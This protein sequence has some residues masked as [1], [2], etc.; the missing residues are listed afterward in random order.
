LIVIEGGDVAELKCRRTTFSM[1]ASDHD[2]DAALADFAERQLVVGDRGPISVGRSNATLSP[3]LPA[4]QERLVARRWCPSGVPKPAKL[5]ASSRAC[6]GSR[7]GECRGCREKAPGSLTSRRKVDA[8]DI[9]GRC[10]GDRSAGRKMVVKLVAR[11][12]DFSS[13][14]APNVSCSQRALGALGNRFH[15]RGIIATS[16][17]GVA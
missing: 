2:A 10:R 15:T 12:G 3:V 6:R 8:L 7:S 13:A 17:G 1:S 14:Q 5:G 4:F 9:L 11:S 16:Y